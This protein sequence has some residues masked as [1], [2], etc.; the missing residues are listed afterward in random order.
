MHVYFI[1]SICVLSSC[2]NLNL[3]IIQSKERIPSFCL[4]NS[5]GQQH[6]NVYRRYIFNKPFEQPTISFS[7]VEYSYMTC[8][9][10]HFRFTQGEEY[11][12][13]QRPSVH[14]C[15]YFY[16]YS[17][18]HRLLY[19]ATSTIKE[20]LSSKIYP[21]ASSTGQGLRISS[22]LKTVRD[23]LLQRENS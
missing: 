11:R 19:T 23:T 13:L 12:L 6:T 22:S 18:Y 20:V 10:L 17:I 7:N 15:I 9:S 8:N 4:Y 2:I 14:I 1:Y 21:H 3:C 16:I 5:S